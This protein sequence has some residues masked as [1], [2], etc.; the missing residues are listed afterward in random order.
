M[1]E[2][3][4]EVAATHGGTRDIP[5]D[6]ALS[7]IE[8]WTIGAVRESPAFD[9]ARYDRE[10]YGLYSNAAEWTSTW[11]VNYPKYASEPPLIA[12][13]DL[14]VIRGGSIRAIT[15]PSF[16][17]EEI[18]K[19]SDVRAVWDKG[20]RMRELAPVVV[21]FP[22]LG[23]RCARSERPRLREREFPAVTGR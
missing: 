4:Y 1:D 21:G 8:D 13:H 14:R 7:D 20:P 16:P 23:F 19:A 5:W 17:D 2:A 11:G 6:G 22:G 9:V 12:P 10:V 18:P 15:D 3:E